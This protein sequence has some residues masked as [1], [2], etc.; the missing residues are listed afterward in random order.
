MPHATVSLAFPPADRKS[1]RRD[2]LDTLYAL[3]RFRIFLR[4]AVAAELIEDFADNAAPLSIFAPTDAAFEKAGDVFRLLDPER[5]EELVDRLEYHLCRGRVDVEAALERG[6][7]RSI[8]GAEIHLRAEGRDVY[9]DDARILGAPI[10]C[11]NGVL[12]VIDRVLVPP[13]VPPLA[14]AALTEVQPS[15]LPGRIEDHDPRHGDQDHA[16]LLR[17]EA[18]EALLRLPSSPVR[19]APVGAAQ[20]VATLRWGLSRGPLPSE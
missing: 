1:P 15:A 7:L 8:H 6:T 13:T 2:L 17:A 20:A 12:H 14:R 16:P 11:N 19:A 18:R 3:G 9:A 4:M 5:E 10:D